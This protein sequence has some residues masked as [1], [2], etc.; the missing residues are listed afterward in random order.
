[1]SAVPTVT[2]PF[3]GLAVPQSVPGVPSE[4][5][6]PRRA[7]SDG[8]AYDAQAK[9]LAGLFADNFVQYEAAATPDVL[10]AAIKP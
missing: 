1:L 4:V 5:L 9:R 7:W 2:E 6:D 10:A 8:A 3:F